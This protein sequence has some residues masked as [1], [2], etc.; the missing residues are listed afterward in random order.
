MKFIRFDDA[1]APELT[2]SDGGKLKLLVQ[3]FVTG[4]ELELNPDLCVLS[5]GIHPN[6]SNKPLSEMLKVPLNT[7][8]FFLEAHMKL[9][10]VD[11]YTEGVFL[12]GLAH[13]PKSLDEAL[14]QAYGTVARANTVLSKD[15]LELG[16]IVA[17]VEEEKC[18][19]CLTCVRVCPF[20]VPQINENNV[21][22]IELAKCQGCGVCVAECPAKAIQLAHFKDRQVLAETDA[23]LIVGGEDQ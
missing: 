9:R 10:P 23:L 4:E 7:D 19:V 8:G 16:G 3:D 18:A 17:S 20:Q 14:A 11:F 15:F 12:C 2:S 21:A 22:Y 5:T 13:S 1:K 6:E